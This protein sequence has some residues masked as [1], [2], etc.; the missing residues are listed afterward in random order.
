MVNLDE[1][2]YDLQRKFNL[3]MNNIYATLMDDRIAK[4]PNQFKG[5]SE[6]LEKSMKEIN[7]K[8]LESDHVLVTMYRV[9]FDA[10]TPD[11][12]IVWNKDIEQQ[13]PIYPFRRRWKKLADSMNW[14]NSYILLTKQ[15]LPL[16]SKENVDYLKVIAKLTIE[17]MKNLFKKDRV[18][19]PEYLRRWKILTSL[20]KEFPKES[21]FRPS[22]GMRYVI[23]FN[24]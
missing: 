3:D 6:F 2:L 4:L 15:I 22:H 23:S 24:R 20:A 9:L 13:D 7:T 16:F 19:N 21:G 18:I 12:N 11:A 8:S 1:K 10:R 17:A 14:V 5:I